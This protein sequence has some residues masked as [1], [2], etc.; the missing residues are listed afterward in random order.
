MKS[1]SLPLQHHTESRRLVDRLLNCLEEQWSL[2]N[3]RAGEAALSHLLNPS[4]IQ[5]DHALDFYARAAAFHTLVSQVQAWFE[6][7]T[8]TLGTFKADVSRQPVALRE[9]S[10]QEARDTAMKALL[11]SDL[12][13]IELSRTA[14]NAHQRESAYSEALRLV[15]RV[16]SSAVAPQAPAAA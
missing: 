2:D 4:G 1:V 5:G 13:R 10:A 11:A 15:N 7:A 6:V 3:R 16:L 9:T 14:R 12:Q 8:G